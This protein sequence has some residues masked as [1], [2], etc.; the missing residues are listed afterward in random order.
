MT[1]ANRLSC[2]AGRGKD[3]LVV[4]GIGSN[5][6]S[7]RDTLPSEIDGTGCF[8]GDGTSS[9][10]SGS[11]A[12]FGPCWTDG[13]GT[14]SNNLVAVFVHCATASSQAAFGMVR[15][16]AGV[17]TLCKLRDTATAF[18]VLLAKLPLQSNI[19]IFRHG[20]G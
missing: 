12:L 19:E 4:A 8:G 14:G 6:G 15:K 18:R 17:N 20:T 13:A 7:I 3:T 2:S 10:C 1:L 11:S 5:A 9:S 16:G